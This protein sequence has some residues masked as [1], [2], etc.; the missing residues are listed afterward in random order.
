MVPMTST[1]RVRSSK[2]GR[3]DLAPRIARDQVLEVGVE[4][5]AVRNRFVDPGIAEDFSA[6]DHAAVAALLIV[7]LMSPFVIARSEATKQSR[8]SPQ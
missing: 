8:L 3:P 4:G 7:H 1:R 5:V 2:C 6:L